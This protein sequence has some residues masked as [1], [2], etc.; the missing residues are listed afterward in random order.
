MAKIYFKTILM[1]VAFVFLFFL[2]L[3]L[4]N[5]TVDIPN[6]FLEFILAS[7]TVMILIN[8]KLTKGEHWTRG[9]IFLL[10]FLMFIIF[11]IILR[12]YVT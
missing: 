1:T 2:R 11:L 4:L 6:P 10:L 9:H 12:I 3:R 5:V 8:E 7:L